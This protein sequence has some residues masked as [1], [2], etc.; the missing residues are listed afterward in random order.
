MVEWSSAIPELT[1]VPICQQSVINEYIYFVLISYFN[2]NYTVQR[3]KRQR[4]AAHC[5]AIDKRT[6]V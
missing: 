4:H 1:E 5:L 6:F 3:I 2:V